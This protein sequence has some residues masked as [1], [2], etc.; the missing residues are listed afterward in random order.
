V[1]QGQWIEKT[2]GKYFDARSDG[3]YVGNYTFENGDPW[4][5]DNGVGYGTMTKTWDCVSYAEF[6]AADA[7]AEP[8]F[9][10]EDGAII[11]DQSLYEG[12]FNTRFDAGEFVGP[13]DANVTGYSDCY[14]ID[15]AGKLFKTNNQ[16]VR[17][18]C[19]YCDDASLTNGNL[20]HCS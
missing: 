17:Y 2:D 1:Y 5:N 20:T 8:Y 10:Y 15:P 7:N 9:T 11:T 19:R 4:P 13:E 6:R 16:A 12:S 14:F 18:L 3:I